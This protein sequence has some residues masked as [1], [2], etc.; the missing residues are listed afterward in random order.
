[1]CVC[2]LA[3]SPFAWRWFELR[4]GDL[5]Y[6]NHK[7]SAERK[8]NLRLG[9]DAEIRPV[10]LNKK[11]KLAAPL[12][13]PAAGKA[14]KVDLHD[15]GIEVEEG[16]GVFSLC[17][18]TNVAREAWITALK[19]AV[20]DLEHKDDNLTVRTCSPDA[21]MALTMIS[22]MWTVLARSVA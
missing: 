22:S 3:D 16:D 18:E 15:F 9:K 19:K 14:K 13:S 5:S 1:M 6:F 7:D 21:Q 4:G 8:G 2:G 11:Q 17:C 12:R 20:A 10:K